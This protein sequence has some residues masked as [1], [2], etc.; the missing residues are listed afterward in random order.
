ME[1]WSHLYKE[2]AEII[3]VNMPEVSWI[4]LWH[5][6]VS[7]LTEELPFPTPAIFIGFNTLSVD[8]KSQ[9]IQDCDT[10]VDFYFFYETFADTYDGA[11]NQSS[12]IEFLETLTKIHT[13][14]HGTNGANF[15]T[16]RRVFMGREDSGDAG[17]LYRISFACI[18]EDASA[19]AV[20]NKQAVNEIDLEKADIQRPSNQDEAPLYN[21][22]Y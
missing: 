10:Q 13:T 7:Y 17:N 11:Y 19:Q 14:F 20:Y 8:D 18:I 12:A 4:D 9:L 22:K 3:K 16:M 1:A 6:Q 15:N 21:I 2:I 5:E